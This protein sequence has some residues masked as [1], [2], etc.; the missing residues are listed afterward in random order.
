[1]LAK[2]CQSRTSAAIN[3]ATCKGTLTLEIIACSGVYAVSLF[4][5]L[6][7]TKAA[8]ALASGPTLQIAFANPHARLIQRKR[9][10]EREDAH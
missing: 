4:R 1:M 2:S 5:G 10:T 7:A 9:R 3:T 6:N 8:D